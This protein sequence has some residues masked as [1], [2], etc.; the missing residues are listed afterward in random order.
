MNQLRVWAPKAKRVDAAIQGRRLPMRSIQ[1]GW[2]L[3]ESNL[4]EPGSDYAFIL[5]DGD[6]RPDPRSEWQPHGVHG[7]SRIVDHSRFRWNDDDRKPPPLSTGVIYEL[8]L[9]TFSPEGTPWGAAQRLRHLVDLGVTHVELMPV[10]SFSGSR[11]WGY[12]GVGLFAPHEAYGGPD[13]IKLFVDACHAHGLAV[14]LDVVYNHLG[15]EGNYLEE[16]GPY[17]TDRYTTLWGKAMNF[18]GAESHEVR[19]FVCDNALMWL[20]D[21]HMDGLRIDAVHAI[22]DESQMHILEQ[23]AVEVEELRGELGRNLVLIAESDLNDPRIVTPREQGGYGIDAQWSDDF[24][25]AMHAYLTGERSGYYADFGSLAD[26][27]KAL[28]KGFVYDGQHSEYRGKNHGQPAGHLSGHRFLGYA[29][30]HDQV[31]NRA[32]GDRLSQIL[33]TKMLKVISALV[34]TSPFIPMLFQGE[35]WG[36]STPFQYFTDH[37]DPALGRAVLE[38]RRKEFSAFGWDPEAIPDPQSE[39]TFRRSKLN[40]DEPDREPHRSLLKWHK[41]LIRLRGNLPALTRGRL[42]HVRVDFEEGARWMKMERGSVTVVCNF[43]D[44]QR[45]VPLDGGGRLLLSSDEGVR[46][47]SRA[48]VVPGESVAIIGRKATT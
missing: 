28:Q 27:A 47:E 41:L 9:G 19:R 8:H 44:L 40:W 4:A 37:Q 5:D 35:E 34:F 25:H 24:H 11:G 45:E 18:D 3:I 31:G 48:A 30:T 17:L 26:I 32:L 39:E 29:Q 36:A 15:P 1:G 38:G 14:I 21:Y 10:N 23:L 20:R 16:F 46:V 43:G 12:D 7:P 13:G 6:P 2:W 33:S 42:D 22:F